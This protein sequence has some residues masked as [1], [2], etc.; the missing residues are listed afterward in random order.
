MKNTFLFACL[1]IL[2]NVHAQDRLKD[3]EN[4]RVDVNDRDEER[5]NRDNKVYKSNTE[6]LFDYTIIKNKD[7][8]K[9][10]F[11]NQ[12]YGIPKWQLVKP[13]DA[14]SL[15]VYSVG[16]AILPY[17]LNDDQTGINFRYYNKYGRIVDNM[18]STGLI[19]NDKNTWTHPPRE[20][21]FAITEFNS[22]PFIK[23]PYTIGTKWTS[24]L[25]VGYFESYKRFN[26]TWEGILNTKETLEIID[27]IQ[28]PTALGVLP[29]FVVKGI[30]TSALTESTSLFYYNETFGFVKIVYDLFD[31][32]R[33]EFNLREIKKDI[34]PPTDALFRQ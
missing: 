20:Q 22:F 32:S 18:A 29:C 17:Y 33:L 28:L 19:E 13:D 7:T 6:F 21:F 8:L 16:F 2:A 12:E 30:C 9:C 34:P 10:R 11:S 15:T 31:K 4:D 27:K 1:L 25:T 14:D 26:L 23:T 24:G 3:L 5:Y